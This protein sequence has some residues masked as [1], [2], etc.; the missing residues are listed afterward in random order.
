MD[1]KVPLSNMRRELKDY[2]VKSNLKSLVLGVSGGIDSA[3]V[4]AIA[5]PV[6]DELEIKLIGRS[7]PTL[8]NLSDEVERADM[9][10][11]AFCHD[12]KVV[13]I[14]NRVDTA[15]LEVE[16]DYSSEEDDRF[17]KI[18]IG[19]I[20]ARTRMIHLYDLAYR[21][22]G[23]VMSTDNFSELMVG[24]WTLKGDEGDYGLIQ[25]L[26][27]TEVYDLSNWVC[28][29]ELNG[30]DMDKWQA[31]KVC[32]DATPTDGLGI[33]ASDTEQLGAPSYDEVDQIL[34]TW[35]TE[36]QDSFSWDDALNYPGRPE[37][38]DVFVRFRET[39]KDHPVVQ[40]HI[41]SEFKRM[42]P[43]NLKRTRIFE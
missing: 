43:I 41:R 12:Y 26:W 33:T 24:F 2:I 32:V 16:H 7:L 29:Y 30:V 5:R 39:L 28:K 14:S 8:T 15:L 31:L 27:K 36:D 3:L 10:G 4:A 19:N 23:M 22:R 34:K 40:R 6:C 13:N 11:K 9:V 1:W 37:A 20:K 25:N 35:L 42:I 21:T 18:A 38:Y 17:N